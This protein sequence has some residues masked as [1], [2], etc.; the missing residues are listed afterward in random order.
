MSRLAACLAAAAA[1]A[2]ALLSVCAAQDYPVRRITLVVPYTAGSGFDIVAR[3]LGQRLS[4]RWGQPV[5]VD[6]RP[7]ASGNI[8]TEFVANAEPDGYTLLVTG[9][10][11]TVSPSLHRNLRFDPVKSFV[12]LGAVGVSGVALVVNPTAFPVKTLPEFIAAIKAKPG[13][14]NYSSPGTGTLQHLG[15]ELLRQRLGLDVVHVPYRGAANALTDLLSGQVQFA[16]LP[17][18]TALPQVKSGKLR[19]LAVAN[20]NRS[21]FAPDVPTFADLGYAGVNFDLWYGVFAPA[22]LA[23]AIAKKWETEL[24]AFAQDPE[25]K[26]GLEKQGIV[27]A[28]RDA[29]A[30]G[31]LVASETAR[32]RDV[33]TKAGLKPE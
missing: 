5:V 15:I 28:Y 25:V 20:A 32:W 13:K 17:V 9:A 1:W 26:S 6:N 11:H 16:Y 27:P 19:M 24:A 14:F 8:G 3:A 21:V 30:T 31:A 7:G 10:P 23:P 2:A 33:V 4:D 22:R 12:P 18:H 29:A